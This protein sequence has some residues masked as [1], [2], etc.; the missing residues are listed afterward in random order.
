LDIE[1]NKANMQNLPRAQLKAKSS[2][3]FTPDLDPVPIPTSSSNLY[4]E[5][6]HSKPTIEKRQVILSISVMTILLILSIGTVMHVIHSPVSNSIE[7]SLFASSNTKII[8]QTESR[9]TQI[10]SS[11]SHNGILYKPFSNQ[12]QEKF[13]EQHGN[14]CFSQAQGSNHV[15][16]R[17]KSMSNQQLQR[18]LFKYCVLYIHGGGFLEED[19]SAFKYMGSINSLD[20]F[21][22]EL[23][24]ENKL[25]KE[26]SNSNIAILS[27]E[28]PYIHDG[29]I[30][31]SL[32]KSEISQ[33]MISYLLSVKD[34]IVIRKPHFL[35]EYLYSL[36]Q[37]EL[38]E[39][40]LTVGWKKKHTWKLLDLRCDFIQSNISP[41]ESTQKIVK[42]IGR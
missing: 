26:S 35:L 42:S 24:S 11:H 6:L 8:F 2:S 13:L 21:L 37:N 31:F 16:Q 39:N 30:Y 28:G 15:W 14:E 19:T 9:S 32:P 17:Y 25:E 36:I 20:A 1:V 3:I 23:N 27:S 10:H 22:A 12:E 29:F 33:Q 4:H 5:K 7:S 38:E 34:D 18:Q 40:Q 41:H